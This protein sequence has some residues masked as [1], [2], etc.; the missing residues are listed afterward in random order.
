MTLNIRDAL[1]RGQSHGVESMAPQIDLTK[2]ALHGYHPSFGN[3][4]ANTGHRPGQVLPF[5]LESPR[6]FNFLPNPDKAR[7]VLKNLMEVQ[8]K[9]ITGLRTGYNVEAS[10]RQ[11][12]HAGHMHS[13]P[14]KV[15]EEIS[16]V[17]YAWDERAG[18]PVQTFWMHFIRNLIA[19]PVTTQPGIMNLGFGVPTDLMADMYSFTMLFIEPDPLKRFVVEAWLINGMWPTT[20]GVLESQFDPTAG[21]DVPE[22]SI[23]FKGTPVSTYAIRQLAQAKLDEMNWLNAGH[24]HQPAWVTGPT[25][26]V[27][28]AEGGWKEGVDNSAQSGIALEGN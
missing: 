28:R 7:S 23:E 14:T 17:N 16:V 11:I 1:L 9:S 10:D 19:D 18:K 20:S 26:D 6:G 15:T 27:A 4:I 2:S 3:Y 22:I 12:T 5:L 24:Q 8:P 21:A 25:A 13:D